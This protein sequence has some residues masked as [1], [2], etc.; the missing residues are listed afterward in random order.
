M[1]CKKTNQKTCIIRLKIHAY[2][3]HAAIECFHI[4]LHDMTLLYNMYIVNI[5]C[6]VNCDSMYDMICVRWPLLLSCG[7]SVT[8]FLSVKTKRKTIYLHD[9][10][11]IQCCKSTQ[12][13]ILE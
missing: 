5:N 3:Q 11:Y 6:I 1:L 12:K 7:A 4:Y 10:G 9:A 8:L 2:I 13:A